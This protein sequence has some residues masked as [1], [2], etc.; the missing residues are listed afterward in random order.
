MS[1][2]NG[3]CTEC[4]SDEIYMR[5]GWF[6]NIVVAFLPPRTRVYVCGTCGY[7]AEFIKEDS[8][9]EHVRKNWGRVENTMKRKR[10]EQRTSMPE[11][12]PTPT[13]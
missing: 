5:S 7:L 3:T 4:G 12:T 10:D 13:L 6:H 2:R 8:N 1:M 9:L 11:D